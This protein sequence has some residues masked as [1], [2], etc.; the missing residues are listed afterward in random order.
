MWDELTLAVPSGQDLYPFID[1]IQK[2]VEEMTQINAKLAEEEWRGTN[3]RYRAK[4]FSTVPRINVALVANGI[5]L[6]VGYITRAY[7]SHD[8]RTRL[9]RSL[10]DLMHVKR[11]E[12]VAPEA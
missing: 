4:S 2:Q 5:E 9:N 12:E 10:V 8:T 7:E 3:K 1:A 6:H 11:P